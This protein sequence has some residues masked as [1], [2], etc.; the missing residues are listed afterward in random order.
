[1]SKRLTDKVSFDFIRYANCW[2]DGEILVKGLNPDPGSKILSIGSAGD[3]CF[4]LLT[5]KPSLVVASDINNIQLYLI[6]LKKAGIQSL[7]YTE[8]LCFIGFKEEKESRTLIFNRLKPLISKEAKEYWQRNLS[9]IEQGI[10]Y[11]GKFEKY[12]LFFNRKILPWIH[13][14]ERKKELIALKSES[15]Q[16][17][18]YHTNWDTWKWRLLFKLFFNRYVLGKYGRDPEF[19]KEVKISVNQYILQKTAAHLSSAE[20]QHNF[21]FHFMLMGDFGNELP[22]YLNPANYNLIQQNIEK[23]QI[24]SGFAEEAHTIFGTFNY[25]NL[26]NIFEYMDQNQFAESAKKLVDAIDKNGRIAYWNLMVPRKVSSL[27]NEQMIFLSELS[28]E[29]THIDKGFFY[30]RFIV[31]E[32]L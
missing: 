2:E 3:N 1:M 6:E 19:M 32:K 12:L 14:I 7:S 16:R 29:L 8:F 30:N 31:E 4:S 22:H 9:Q 28:D 23:L 5:T 21:M 27:C 10:I 20:V 11:Q 15:A 26:S 17:S 25:M 24:Y 13:S 18:F